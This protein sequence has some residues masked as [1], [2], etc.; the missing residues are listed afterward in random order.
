MSKLDEYLDGEL[1]AASR[2]AIAAHL[3]ACASC[4]SEAEALGRA[5]H[6]LRALSAIERAPD[7]ALD[8]RP[9]AVGV[10]RRPSFGWAA[11]GVAAAALVTG[12]VLWFHVRVPVGR[13]MGHPPAV[14][15]TRPNVAPSVRAFEPPEGTSAKR[16]SPRL[17]RRSRHHWGAPGRLPGPS[18]QPPEAPMMAS[19]GHESEEL[20]VAAPPDT[21]AAPTV[22]GVI[23]ILGEA[24]PAL[25]SSSYVVQVVFPDGA[26][27]VVE[28]T[29]ERDATG[30]PKTVQVACRQTAPED[31]APDEGGME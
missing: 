19:V 17:A 1:P 16:V 22:E 2:Q 25:A 26:Q 24:Q 6:G 27:S 15:A 11:A 14:V 4:R 21:E 10:K 5:E 18:I 30:L 13:P 23:L 31:G 3:E 29:V 28:R 7:V 9:H 12:M 20:A 8:L